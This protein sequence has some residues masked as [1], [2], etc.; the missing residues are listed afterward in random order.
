[1]QDGVD[2]GAPTIRALQSSIGQA[3]ALAAA[4]GATLTSTTFS[5]HCDLGATI[6]EIGHAVGL[7]HEQ[8]RH[9]RDS[10]VRILWENI[11]PGNRYNFAQHSVLAG[12][13]TGDY[14]YGSIMHYGR[15]AFSR[16]GD[17]T[18]VP[19]DDS[20]TIGQRQG[21][22]PLDIAAVEAMYPGLLPDN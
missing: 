10:H 19:L 5:G 4:S 15:N 13:D 12:V 11:E 2:G 21:L 8:T 6:H 3:S 20:A 7:Y 16:N 1:M 18:I 14:D 22:S 17:D 9:D